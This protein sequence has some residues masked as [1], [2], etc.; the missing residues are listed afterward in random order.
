MWFGM[1]TVIIGLALVGISDIIFGSNDMH[2]KN[3]IITGNIALKQPFRE[4]TI[5]EIHV[6]AF[7]KTTNDYV[8]LR[9]FKSFIPIVF[10]N[11]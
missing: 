11:N 2:D 6:Y 8:Q 4:F 5:Q 3:G 1:F 10:T 9:T 7:R